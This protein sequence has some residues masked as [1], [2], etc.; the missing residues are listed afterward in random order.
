MDPLHFCI[1]MVPLAVYLLMLGLLNLRRTPFVT[2]GARDAAAVGIGI[3]GLVV[4]GPMELFLPQAAASHYG[5]FVWLMMIAFYGMLVS[6]TVLLMR[7]RIVIYNITPEQLRPILSE[8]A[9]DFDNSARWSG[10]G[11]FIPA[12]QVQLH[13]DVSQWSRNIQLVASGSNQSYE[14]WKELEQRL[15]TATSAIQVGPNV[16]SFP[17]LVISSA[18]A[19]VTLIWMLI[20][21][22]AVVA[23]FRNMSEF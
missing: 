1:A 13:L 14:G 7:T 12:K 17:L 2:S 8:V 9:K 3:S 20:D 22:E 21:K 11:L 23:A 6:L 5:A 15:K 19:A 18:L 10:D 16:F 4:A